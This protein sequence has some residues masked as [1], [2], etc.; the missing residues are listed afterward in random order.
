[1]RT[2]SAPLIVA[3]LLLGG[4][5]GAKDTAAT[6]VA[7]PEELDLAPAAAPAPSPAPVVEP[8]APE[9]IAP[10]S[11]GHDFAPQVALLYRIAACG[12][13]EPAPAGFDQRT[14]AS[15]CKSMRRR[16]DS[17]RKRW[18][19]RAMPYLA[20]LRPEGLPARAVYPFGGGDLVTALAT[21]PDAT[22]ITTISLE[23]A[24]DPRT[25]DTL[26]S[27]GLRGDLSQVGHVIGRLLRAAHSTTKSL[28]S[29]SHSTLPGTLV[30]ALAG[31]AVHGFEPVSLRYFIIERDGRLRYLELGELEAAARSFN[32]LAAERKA[33]ERELRKKKLQVWREQVAVFAN[34]E[35]QFRERGKPDA[36]LRTYRHVVANLDNP[37]LADAPGLVAHLSA[38]GPVAAMT[39]A[40]SYL[41]WM[42]EFST[43]RDYLLGH[44]VWM[45][46][47]SS[48]IP[49]HFARAAGF[50]QR[51]YGDY[52]GPYFYYSGRTVKTIRDDFAALWKKPAGALPFRYGY[53]DSTRKGNH[54]LI[55]RKSAP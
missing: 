32:E 42:D 55:T 16:Y 37:H 54:L 34:A 9:P 35:I 44:V 47:D 23:A 13:D 27:R 12:S 33:R 46:S 17:Y 25:I 39:K 19:D 26:S 20:N 7:P 48:G 24:G 5:C 45:A 30:F 14:V 4:A 28:Q 52:A 11:T 1:M 50:E 21:F 6:E 10:A 8:A 22:E 51:A 3:L 31:L 38:K 41:L 36:P 53:P 29:A 18:L 43:I 49:P 40:A 2:S 15:H